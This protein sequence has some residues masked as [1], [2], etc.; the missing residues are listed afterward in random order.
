MNANII[1]FPTRERELCRRYDDIIAQANHILLAS[2]IL[3]QSTIEM[4][5]EIMKYG[6]RG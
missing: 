3:V 4:Q 2:V 1:P 5:L 6:K